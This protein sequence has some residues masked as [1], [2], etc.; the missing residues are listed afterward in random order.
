[1]LVDEP[2]AESGVLRSEAK[3][4]PQVTQNGGVM[5]RIV[6]QQA[7]HAAPRVG[8]SVTRPHTTQGGARMAASRP[9]R[10]SRT[11]ISTHDSQLSQ[12]TITSLPPVTVAR[13]LWPAYGRRA[14]APS[15]WR[16]DQGAHIDGRGITPEPFEAVESAR[17]F[18]EYVHDEVE[19]VEQHSA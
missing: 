12:P 1:M 4:S 3:G 9:S 19:V 5:N 13:P 10:V 18:P 6:C 15:R 17:L 14:S 8:C 11:R 2:A 7:S 16:R